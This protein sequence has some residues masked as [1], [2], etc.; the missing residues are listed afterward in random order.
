MLLVP[1]GDTDEDFA[2]QRVL[3]EAI[4]AI[5]VE[6]EE[7]FG[8]IA[9]MV[10]TGAD[11]LVY[12]A[13]DEVAQMTGMQPLAVRA[14]FLLNGFG[15]SVRADR[16]LEAAGVIAAGNERV[17]ELREALETARG[18]FM[19]PRYARFLIEMNFAAGDDRARPA[20]DALLSA[21]REHCGEDVYLTGVAMSSYDIGAAFEGDLAKVNLITFFA[22]LL[23]VAAS[24]RSLPLPLL[25]VFVI[26]GA[27]WITMG[28]SRLQG[29]P[30][31]FMSYLICVSIQMGATIDY[32]I[33]LSDQYRSLRRAGESSRKALAEAVRRAMPTILTSGV[34]LTTA[35]AII[36]VRCSVY[37][38]SAIG[39]LLSRGA[40]VSVALVLTLLPALLALGDRF[41]A[42]G[43]SIVQ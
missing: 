34:I 14:F 26:E 3:V 8:E 21:A 17:R 9:S 10:T 7:P 27:I 35:G 36:G 4:R 40:A 18:A 39:L 33:L 37:Y 6:G 41:I 30:I 32:G 23:I 1:G 12:Y 16:L 15:E 22:I 43:D 29:A 11:A 20:I 25:I 2:A 31:F 13:A 28:I 19:G 38:I 42:G 24:F 5:R